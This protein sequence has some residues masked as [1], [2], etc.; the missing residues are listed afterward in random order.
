VSIE[1][2]RPPAAKE[3]AGKAIGK[4]RNMSLVFRAFLD[5]V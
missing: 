3:N 2:W 5:F 1:H 4:T